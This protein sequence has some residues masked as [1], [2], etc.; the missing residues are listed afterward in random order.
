MKRNDFEV[1]ELLSKV[2]DRFQFHSEKAKSDNPLIAEM[3]KKM[4]EIEVWEMWALTQE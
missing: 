4:C 3:A 2:V 1:N